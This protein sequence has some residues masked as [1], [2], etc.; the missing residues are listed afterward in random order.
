MISE[1]CSA[2]TFAIATFLPPMATSSALS[3]R[4]TA[5]V[6]RLDHSTKHPASISL[7]FPKTSLGFMD[8]AVYLC[9]YCAF[10]E[11]NLI[12]KPNEIV[13]FEVF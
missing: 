8:S 1:D 13:V 11:S 12:M 9:G 3:R 2:C 5:D 7:Q 4:P 10:D 6:P